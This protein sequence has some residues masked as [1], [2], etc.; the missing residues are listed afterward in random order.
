MIQIDTSGEQPWNNALI[1]KYLE[2]CPLPAAKRFV[3]R[4]SSA[5][6]QAANGID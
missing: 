1:F 4:G 6:H 5:M 2:A 3:E